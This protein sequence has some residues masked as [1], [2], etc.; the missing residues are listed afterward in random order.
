MIKQFFNSEPVYALIV[1]G[2][3]M[4]LSGFL[5]LRVKDTLDE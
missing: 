2:I 5:T 4:I 3:A 1:G